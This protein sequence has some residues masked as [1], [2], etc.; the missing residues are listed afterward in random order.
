M[1]AA[2]RGAALVADHESL[3]ERVLQEIRVES[4]H[5]EVLLLSR[6]GERM[7]KVDG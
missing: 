1:E 2:G 4:A 6:N 7:G 3:P 5:Y